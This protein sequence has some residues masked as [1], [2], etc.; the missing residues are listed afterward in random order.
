MK[1]IL[2]ILFAFFLF[3]ASNVFAD[4]VTLTT[5]YPAPFGMYQ[6]MRV[7]GKLG[8]GTTD[9]EYE[10]EVVHDFANPVASRRGIASA[11]YGDVATSPLVEL[12]KARGTLASPSAVSSSDRM[13]FRVA[14]YDGTA[15]LHPAYV[16][17]VV[18]GNV[19]PG[20]VPTDFVVGTSDG[21]GA[22]FNGLERMRILSTGNVGIGTASPASLVDVSAGTSGDAELILESDT[23][24]NDEDDNP[25]ITFRQDGNFVKAFIGLEGNA[26]ARATGTLQNALVLGSEDIYSALQLVTHDV[27]RMTVE[28]GGD[29][30]IGTTSP[31]ARLHVREEGTVGVDE[32]ARF[33]SYNSDL[34]S[35]IIG[36]ESSAPGLGYLSLYR[37]EVS[38]PKVRITASDTVSTYFNS[39]N[40][41][42]GTT[43]PSASLQVA[44]DIKQGSDFV[45]DDSNRSGISVYINDKGCDGSVGTSALT[46]MQSNATSCPG[47]AAT[48]TGTGNCSQLYESDCL[49]MDDCHWVPHNGGEC[50][51]GVYNCSSQSV[52]PQSNC[53]SMCT[54]TPIGSLSNTFLGVL[55]D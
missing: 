4:D 50:T 14:P 43:N 34:P 19:S 32:I 13:F 11:G 47:A 39:G 38:L 49:N 22:G 18:N 10:L 53:L 36:S 3:F 55:I 1:K 44:G 27:A 41:G 9:P 42:I 54:Y 15:F 24:N 45:L 5:Y 35:V 29:V 48:C 40:V 7:M 37:A 31:K 26:G 21:T 6:E 46:T 16:G 20:V 25:Y 12:K 23:D 8:V 30:G 2:F 52:P 28:T 33:G 17:F 51:G